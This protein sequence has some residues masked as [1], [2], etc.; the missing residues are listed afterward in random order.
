MDND[1]KSEQ[2]GF[3][4]E[5]LIIIPLLGS[6]IAIVFDVGY[7]AGIDLSLFTIF[8][9]NEHILFALAVFPEAI[10][11]A[12]L[13][14]LLSSRS[15]AEGIAKSALNTRIAMAVV[16][17]VIIVVVLAILSLSLGVFLGAASAGFL[18]WTVRIPK[19]GRG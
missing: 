6:A 11:V 2:L 3:D 1:D 15:M 9:L 12:G 16:A 18:L 19:S 4:K 7:F 10:V 13:A 14:G 17:L 8:S 5:L